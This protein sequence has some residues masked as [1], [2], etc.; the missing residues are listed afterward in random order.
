MLPN[1]ESQYE[2]R[3]DQFKLS[4]EH[5]SRSPHIVQ[6]PT[7]STLF[8]SSEAH[9]YYSSDSV[10]GPPNNI[11]VSDISLHSTFLNDSLRRTQS[12]QDILHGSLYR[13]EY[14]RQIALQEHITKQQPTNS[15]IKNN[16][17]LHHSSSTEHLYLL[18]QPP[19]QQTRRVSYCESF[20]KQS[21][22]SPALN[23]RSQSH[24]YLIDAANNNLISENEDS[25]VPRDGQR[26]GF[27]N[28][29][30]PFLATIPKVSSY[31]RLGSPLSSP[32]VSPF[33]SPYHNTNANDSFRLLKVPVVYH[34]TPIN[35]SQKYQDESSSSTTKLVD[36]SSLHMQPGSDGPI[37]YRYKN[38]SNTFLDKRHP[39]PCTTTSFWPAS[40]RESL[41]VTSQPV[42]TELKTVS[43]KRT[44]F[45]PLYI[46][47][48]SFTCIS[49]SNNECAGSKYSVPSDFNSGLSPPVVTLTP[50]V[51]SST[52]S[53]V[54]WGSDRSEDIDIV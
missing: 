25:E 19:S 1:P 45:Q 13:N 46:P 38:Q 36:T 9:V 14:E 26:L 34:P 43:R 44:N 51:S 12:T 54:I 32:N 5:F 16:P 18:N 8:P 27:E 50:P 3:Q 22:L 31:V 37:E 49:S 2:A 33:S 53:S 6:S 39:E 24:E 30:L 20:L 21:R 7:Y 28:Q 47:P 42:Y 10:A 41:H 23:M 4:S 52:L 11:N 48:P 40:T 17:L 35:L 29:P 15:N